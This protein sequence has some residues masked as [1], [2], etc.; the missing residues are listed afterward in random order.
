M[1]DKDESAYLLNIIIIQPW[2][3]QEGRQEEQRL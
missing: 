3:L 2:E 1:F